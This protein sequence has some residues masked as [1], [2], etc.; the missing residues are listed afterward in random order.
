MKF[1]R[2]DRRLWGFFLAALFVLAL[3]WLPPLLAQSD[4]VPEAVKQYVQEALQGDGEHTFSDYLWM[5]V[6]G[7]LVMFMQAGFAMVESGFTRAKN[8]VNI[9]MKNVMDF[10]VGSILYWAIGFG[11]MYGASVG[12][13]IGGSRFFLA[14]AVQGETINNWEYA[15]FFFQLVFAATAATIVSGAMAERTQFRAYLIYSA[16]ISGLIYPIQGHWSWGGGWLSNLGFHDFAGSAIVHSV[17]GWAALMGALIIG[18][19]S[20]KYDAQG[21]PRV[22]P[23]HNILIA[24]LGVFILWLGWFGFNPGSTLGASPSFARIAVTTN[25]AAAAGGVSAMFFAWILV[26]KPDIGLTLNGVLSG[27]VAITAPCA[28]VSPG[29]ALII[30]IVA[31]V[32]C[33]LFVRWFDTVFKVDDPVGAITVHGINGVWGALAVGLFAQEPFASD[34][35]ANP[36]LFF[37]GGLSQLLPQI[38]GVLVIAVWTLVTSGVLFGILR[39]A[40]ALRVTPEEEVEGLDIGEHGTHAYHLEDP[41]L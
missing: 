39:A 38:Y 36:G 1:H 16:I 40:G 25:I 28:V 19:R 23:G 22:I 4:E 17:G 5:M 2:S 11:L 7:F 33:V 14:D 10:S 9:L 29:S 21:R 26:K 12:G 37:G 20:G 15:E 24:A 31:G 32:L 13:W 30:G 27:L 18:P 3:G 8:T 34:G 6:A 41:L 35:G